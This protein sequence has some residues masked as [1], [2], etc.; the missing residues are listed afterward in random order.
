MAVREQTTLDFAL[1]WLAQSNV[2]YA[3]GP[4]RGGVNQGYNWQSQTYPFLYSKITGYAISTF[5]AAYRW[6]D[7]VEYLAYAREAANFL[8]RV[9]ETGT[10]A[11]VKG[12][13]P[14]GLTNPD[15]KVKRQYYSFD[16]AMGMQGLLDLYRVRP[17]ADLLDAARAAGDWLVMQMQQPDGAFLSMYDA[18]TGDSQ[19]PGMQFFNDFG[20]LHAKHAI[21]LL[22]LSRATGDQRYETA[23][24]K[25]CEWALSL[26]DADGSFRASEMLHQVVSL[27]HCYAAEGLLYAHFAL[28]DEKYLRAAVR[29]AEWLLS[30]QNRDGSIN[31]AYKQ[32]WLKM[33]RR[34]TEMVFPRKVTD[35]TAQ[36]M[37]LW[38]LLYLLNGDPRMMEAARKAAD[39]VREMQVA[40][41]ADPN[42]SGGFYFWPGH[43]I[44][45]TWT[46]MFACQALYEIEHFGNAGEYGQ[47]IEEL[48]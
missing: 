6:T 4:A 41:T 8:L 36:A 35:A 25:V 44:L 22:K 14:H 30:V 17:E 1:G 9:Q 18:E 11:W 23:A 28:D 3:T 32:D 29:A 26:Q 20:C 15:L 46:A 40:G 27:S 37:R 48:F 12:A 16:V 13:I 34:I 43:P 38:T 45:F 19:H 24:R 5:V 10:D 33:G 7:S 42:A 31:I 47:F 2:R 21:G 39:F